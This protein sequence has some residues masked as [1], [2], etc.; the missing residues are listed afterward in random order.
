M[1]LLD[2]TRGMYTRGNC[3]FVGIESVLSAIWASTAN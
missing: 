2:V 1:Q 3:F